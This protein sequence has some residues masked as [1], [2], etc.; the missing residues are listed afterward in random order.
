[1]TER[2]EH[3]AVLND[4]Y[5]YLSGILKM[6]QATLPA[7]KTELEAIM[8]DRLDELN[9]S[10]NSQQALLLQTKNFDQKTAE[11]LSKLEISADNLTEM[12]TKLPSEEQMRFFSLIGEFEQTVS[13]VSFYRDKCKLLLQ[14]KLYHIDKALSKT[15]GQKDNTT[16]D[17]KASGVHG[18]LI[19]K[20]F[21]K[22]I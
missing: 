15:A 19:P 8:E 16:Y 11:Y 18:S 6:Y 5:E 4:F 2:K 7:L 21:E 17:Q 20:S 3:N 14:N 22:K 12:V 13:E 9:K 10:L 1:M